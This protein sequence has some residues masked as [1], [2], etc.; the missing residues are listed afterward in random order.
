[1]AT[2]VAEGYAVAFLVFRGPN[3]LIDR[4]SATHDATIRAKP[5]P[6]D[7]IDVFSPRSR[8][9]AKYLTKIVE[10]QTPQRQF[11]EVAAN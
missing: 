9:E 5:T 6:V 3:D 7:Q 2:F 1:V 10:D 4:L 8:W 11:S